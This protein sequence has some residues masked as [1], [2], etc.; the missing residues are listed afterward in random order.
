[1]SIY[2]GTFTY[3]QLLSST[4][5]NDLIE[6]INE[7]GHDDVTGSKIDFSDLT[8]GIT[9]DMIAANTLTYAKLVSNTLRIINIDRTS[10]HL[11]SDGYA[12]YAP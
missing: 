11:S 3:Q 1:M 5:L 9:A 8:G 6:A 2:S 7:H 12:T 10:I 4:Q